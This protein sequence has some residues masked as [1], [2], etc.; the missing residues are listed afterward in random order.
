MSILTASLTAATRVVTPKRTNEATGVTAWV[1]SD[2]YSD[3]HAAHWTAPW[4]EGERMLM[5]WSTARDGRARA[6]R[7][8]SAVLNRTDW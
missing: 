7:A 1:T 5:S 8:A 2:A 3:T 4:F 6:N